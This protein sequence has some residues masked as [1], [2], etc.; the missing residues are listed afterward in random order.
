MPFSGFC[1]HLHS[2]AHTYKVTLKAVTF[3]LI[4]KNNT[5]GAREMAL[6]V[7]ALYAL[8]EDQ[9]QFLALT[10]DCSQLPGIL[11]L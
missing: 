3:S 11:L 6:Q 9:A 4:I 5:L 2:C 8:R 1:G 7:R 10:P